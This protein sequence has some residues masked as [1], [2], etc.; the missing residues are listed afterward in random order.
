MILHN[1][2]VIR[3][4]EIDIYYR[5]SLDIVEKVPISVSDD[6]L[7]LD[8][9]TEDFGSSS[10]TGCN[11]NLAP[12]DTNG[13]AEIYINTLAPFYGEGPADYVISSLKKMTGTRNFLALSDSKKGCQIEDF[14]EC[15]NRNF[16]TQ[17]K[18][19]CGNC[20][21]W[22]LQREGNDIKVRF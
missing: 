8:V 20:V 5:L 13:L 15:K 1:F 21:P 22:I 2:Y 19:L 6:T 14:V 18:L 16:F 3:P 9:E 17:G 11:S 12:L 10:F 4:V 7:S